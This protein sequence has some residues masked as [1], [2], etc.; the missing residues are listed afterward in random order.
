MLLL[1]AVLTPIL[2]SLLASPLS[3][4]AGKRLGWALATIPASL[5]IAL[6][7]QVGSL[8]LTGSQSISYNWIPGLGVNLDL[9]LDGL[10]L[11]FALMICGVGSFIFA[12]AGGYLENHPQKGRFFAFLM[13]FMTGMMGI[14]TA[15][16]IILFFVFW[17][18]TSISS[19][20]LIGFNHEDIASRKKALQAL[21]VTGFGGVAMMAGFILLA[22]AGGSTQLSV[23][24]AQGPE[25][26]QHPLAVAALPFILLGAFTKSAQFPFQFWLP[27]AMAAPTPV[28]AY[29][30]SATM[31]KAGVFLLFKLS[32]LYGQSPLWTYALVG[33]GAITLLLGAI[34]GLFQRDLKRIL[35]FTTMS[36]LGML[37]MLIGLGGEMALKSALLFM[38]AHA[39]YK[40][41]LFMTAGNVDHGTGTR[42]VTFLGGLRHLMPLTALAAGLAALSKGGFPPL[43]G[44]IS[45]EYV[46]KAST[47]LDAFATTLTV[48]AIV[49]NAMLLALAFKA[50]IHPYWSKP[51]E[52]AKGKTYSRFLP[53]TPHEA[54]VSMILG[55]LVLGIT[56]LAFGFLPSSWI[57]SLVAPAL[58]NTLGVATEAKVS[59]WHG[60]NL[61]LL[62]SFVTLVSGILIYLAREH[63]WRKQA[64]G[65][66]IEKKST[67]RVY[68][69]TFAQFV[70]KSKELTL[71]LQNGSM[72]SYLWIILSVSGA[73]LAYKLIVLGGMPSMP[74]P[75]SIT[76]LN[77]TIAIVIAVSAIYA[78]AARNLLEATAGLGFVGYSIALVYGFNGAPDLAITQIVVETLTVALLLYAALKLPSMRN[79]SSNRNRIF[80][81]IFAS[82]G[83]LIACVIVL[84]S[85]AIEIAPTIST[86]LSEWSYPLAKGRN[87]VNVILVDFRA[88]DTFGEI[89]VLGV[90]ALGV[91]ICLKPVLARSSNTNDPGLIFQFGARI[92]L[93]L[94][95]A[96]SLIA[97]YRG[98]NEPGGGF[99]G[100]LIFAAG[101]ILYGMAFGGQAARRKLKASPT[102]YIG[103]GLLVALVSGLFGP[104]IGKPFLSALWLPDFTLPLLGKVHLGTP[105][106]FDV[107]VFLVVVGFTLQVVFNF[108]S[109]S[110]S[111]AITSKKAP[112]WNS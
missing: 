93:P 72:R 41:T 73:L 49:G 101:F 37:V 5:F 87:I 30:H 3:K 47:N 1:S 51:L 19:Y 79:Y 97:L 35:A 18:L 107:G 31:V 88:L 99:I 40:A 15:D 25:L 4:V 76:F 70:E 33:C 103:S 65:K 39:L 52:P 12:Y 27:N 83:G 38:L 7:L 67:E 42:E 109:A 13:L 9:R 108:Q 95:V 34:T 58:S 11:L 77:T 71:F 44:F 2:G 91:S 78:A 102:V 62:L 6:L 56:G 61:P 28:S 90:A 110:N 60:F 32:P 100:G 105:L 55:P 57:S 80:D 46:Y 8:D 50:G 54:P 24:I 75:S 16:D 17:E 20:L 66:E 104:A 92:L 29:L 89:A 23:L 45:K 106:L 53:H 81:A 59:L 68:D 85:S 86:Q 48:I 22:I 84:K 36:V 111:P 26:A 82:L 14:A 63:F 96:L 74:D 94:C 43:L 64:V 69:Y 10:G 112:A 21:L 98:H